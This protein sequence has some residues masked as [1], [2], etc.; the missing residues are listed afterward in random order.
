MAVEQGADEVDIVLSLSAFLSGDH[1]A[2]SEEIRQVRRCID[3]VAAK[4]NREVHLK[5]ILETGNMVGFIGVNGQSVSIHSRF[6]EKTQEDFFLHY[7]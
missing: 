4:Q 7:M 5:V 2:A 6:S 1:E 3:Q